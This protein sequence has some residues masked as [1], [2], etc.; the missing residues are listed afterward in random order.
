MPQGDSL[1]ASCG[2]LGACL[3][4]ANCGACPLQPTFWWPRSTLAADHMADAGPRTEL[5]ADLGS[6][7]ATVKVM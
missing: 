7:M 5:G 3:A 1:S 2:Q 4:L 6:K